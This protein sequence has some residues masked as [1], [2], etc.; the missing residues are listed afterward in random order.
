LGDHQ[1][2]GNVL[3]TLCGVNLC[4][5]HL[6]ALSQCRIGGFQLAGSHLSEPFHFRFHGIHGA[7]R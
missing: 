5:Q 7:F 2:R 4:R 1:L 6:L 3:K